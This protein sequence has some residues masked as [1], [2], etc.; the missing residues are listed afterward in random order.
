MENSAVAN[1]GMDDLMYM[2]QGLKYVVED[3]VNMSKAFGDVTEL[4]DAGTTLGTAF[5]EIKKFL[6]VIFYGSP[7]GIGDPSVAALGRIVK[8]FEENKSISESG[9]SNA[10]AGLKKMQ[11]QMPAFIQTMGAVQ[12][13]MMKQVADIDIGGSSA[14]NKEIGKKLGAIQAMIAG[15]QTLDAAL[16][17]LPK[18]NLSAHMGKVASMVGLG[19]GGIYTVKTRDVKIEIHL[20]VTMKAGD[21][22]EIMINSSASLIKDRVNLLLDAVQDEGKDAKAKAGIPSK[23][24]GDGN[25]Q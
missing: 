12:D 17:N 11:E 9:L 6:N 16:S 20:N 5:D 14:V 3:A 10:T 8:I 4:A 23:K 22:E 1:T 21:I 2:I 13:D 25:Y 15:V 24:F 7:E 18:V 19:G